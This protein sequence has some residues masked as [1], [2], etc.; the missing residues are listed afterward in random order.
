MTDTLL[1][2]LGLTETASDFEPYLV[3]ATV[4][5]YNPDATILTFQHKNKRIH[6]VLP[7]TEQPVN[8]RW[9][10]GGTHTLALLA[11][12]TSPMPR[13]S[14]IHPTVI[15]QSLGALVPEIYAGDV[16]VMRI[17]RRAGQRTKVAVAATQP[18]IDPVSVTVGRRSNRVLALREIL[19][20][21]QVDIVAWHPDPETFIR[22]ALQPA[23]IGE[24]TFDAGGR[25]VAA[26]TP[27]HQMSAAV[28]S[29]GLNSALAGRL[30]DFKIRIVPQ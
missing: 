25:S 6:G 27:S 24:L 17:A 20:G 10:K 19:G 21:E 29:G 12:P 14:A 22:N 8:A 16:R 9:H 18:G 28:G 4:D 7:I 2:D 26:Q 3:T 5:S 23:E 30:T 15:T 11:P 1:F 13:L